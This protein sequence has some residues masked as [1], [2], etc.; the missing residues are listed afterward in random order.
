MENSP[1]GME[2]RAQF[3]Q[4]IGRA[5]FFQREHVRIYRLDTF[6]DFGF[7]FGGFDMRTRFG[8]LIQV[9]FNVVSRDAK[10]F[11]G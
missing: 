10:S 9:I 1:F 5:H 7:G 4:R 3:Q 8:R 11:G 6:A 2:R